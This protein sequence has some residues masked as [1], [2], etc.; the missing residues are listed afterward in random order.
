M[1]VDATKPVF[2]ASEKA[3][4]KSVST[5]TETSQ[6]IENSQVANLDMV[7]SK[8]RKIKVL[9]SLRGCAGWSAHLLFTN[10]KDMFSQVEAQISPL[11]GTNYCKPFIMQLL[12]HQ[13][14]FYLDQPIGYNYEL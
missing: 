5:A 1:G 4:L 12:V 2:R 6:K 3:R 14:S 11:N 13:S 10:P 8:K 9:I 7:L